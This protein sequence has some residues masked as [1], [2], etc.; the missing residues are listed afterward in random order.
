MTRVSIRLFFFCVII[1]ILGSFIYL[2]LSQP[3]IAFVRSLDLISEFNG[4]KTA[5]AEYQSQEGFWKS[6]IDTLKWR[7]Q[8]EVDKFTSNEKAWSISEKEAQKTIILQLEKSIKQYSLA[9]QEQAADKEKKITQA[10]L[11]QINSFIETY[12]DKHGYDFVIGADGGGAL[13]YGQKKH[14][15]TEDLLREL[16]REYKVLPVKE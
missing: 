4:M 5:Q 9:I 6:N 15:I 10:V 11:N 3:K 13:L 7:Y 1:L 14:D 12:A 16:N 8:Q 2:K